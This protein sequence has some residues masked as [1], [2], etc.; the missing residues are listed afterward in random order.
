MKYTKFNYLNIEANQNNIIH[1]SPINPL[2]NVINVNTYVL[3]KMT[4]QFI[5]MLED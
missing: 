3:L 1:T 2:C 4:H 5:L